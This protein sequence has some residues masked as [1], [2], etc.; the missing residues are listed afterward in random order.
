LEDAAQAK[1][2]EVEKVKRLHWFG[3]LKYIVVEI[4]GECIRPTCKASL[5][6]T[7]SCATLRGNGAAAISQTWKVA[8]TKYFTGHF[9]DMKRNDADVPEM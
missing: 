7:N 3:P 4:Y 8:H 5:H 2:S 9:P 1:K 6:S